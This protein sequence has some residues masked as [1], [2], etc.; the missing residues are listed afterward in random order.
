MWRR[1]IERLFASAGT[2]DRAT[3]AHLAVLERLIGYRF[4]R[5]SLLVD[6]LKHR[7]ALHQLNEDRS[8]SNERLEFLGDAVLDFVVAEYFYHL[9]PQM[10][11]GELTKLRSV[12]CS[13]S[14]LARAAA[15]LDLGRFVILS[16]NEERTGG[17]ERASILEDAF[18]GLI[19]AIYLD[20]GLPP[21]RR[22]VEGYLLDNWRDV[23]KQREFVNYK[24]LILEHAQAKQWSAPVY[25]LREECGPD[26]S[27]VFVVELLINGVVYGRGEGRSKK[28]AEQ[29]AALASAEKLGL[30]PGVEPE[31]GRLGR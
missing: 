7:S 1:L 10:V 30:L 22:F 6:A 23:V 13:G 16:A 18:E 24:S 25:A 21:A 17:R 26:H 5:R 29:E 2:L 20:G 11:E 27:K 14:V 4:R 3:S 28:A 12:I 15:K 9:F 8:R 31:S 19:G